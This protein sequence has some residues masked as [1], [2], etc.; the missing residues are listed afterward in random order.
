MGFIFQGASRSGCASSRRGG[1]SSLVGWLTLGAG[2]AALATVQCSGSTSS[3]GS[4][5]GGSSAGSG[6]GNSTG[7]SS[8][9][10]TSTPGG[11]DSTTTATG[12]SSNATGSAAGS[13]GS[14]GAA[15]APDCAPQDARGTGSGNCE[16]NLG[17]RWTGQS[18]EPLYACECEGAD[19]AAL[20]TTFEACAQAYSGCFDNTVCSDERLAIVDLVN[21]NKACTDTSDCVTEFVGCGVTE[22][23]CTGAVYGNAELDSD[24]LYRLGLR[25]GTCSNAFENGSEWCGQCD[26]IPWPP[27][28]VDGRCIAEEACGLENNVMRNFVGLNK[29]C[30]TVDDCTMAVVG[31]GVSEDGC[32]G[33]VY[34]SADFDRTEFDSLRSRVY[35]CA[36]DA[37]PCAVC[38]RESSPVAC[39]A[40]RCQRG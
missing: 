6:S 17:S 34:L 11:A 29:D 4:S 24:E 39:V 38:E 18:C 23:D 3:S 16:R 27:S 28:C 13:S 20:S 14:A 7:G 2:L 5:T 33:T 22:D 36:A 12:G 31:C 26:R 15:G 1:A 40:G 30:D 25:L 8:T 32:T 9:G 10:T 21:A 37:E 35:A 19:C